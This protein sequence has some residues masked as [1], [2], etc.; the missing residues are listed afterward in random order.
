MSLPKNV[1]PK[2][3]LHIIREYSKPLTRPNWRDSKPLL[4]V[5]EL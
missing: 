3:V 2:N 5:Y 4:T 1:L